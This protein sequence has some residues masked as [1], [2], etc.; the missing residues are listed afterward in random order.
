V[1]IEE[2]SNPAG[3]VDQGGIGFKLFLGAQEHHG[4][5]LGGAVPHS[6]RNA[7][8]G[9]KEWHR[10]N[11]SQQIWFLTIRFYDAV[12][13]SSIA[14][15][16]RQHVKILYASECARISVPGSVC[17]CIRD[18]TGHFRIRSCG[19]SKQSVSL[20]LG[21]SFCQVEHSTADRE[22]H[23]FKPGCPSSSGK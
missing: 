2:Q 13:I 9:G 10:G 1:L 6:L 23:R 19:A 14:P 21:H 7:A 12:N 20:T 16:K 11:A 18:G 5:S 17:S 4:S 22:C 3:A 15:K 8:V